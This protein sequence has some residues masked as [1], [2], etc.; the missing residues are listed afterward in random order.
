MPTGNNKL[1]FYLVIDQELHAKIIEHPLDDAAK[2]SSE[3]QNPAR[4]FD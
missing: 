1:T 4:I 2:G 3:R